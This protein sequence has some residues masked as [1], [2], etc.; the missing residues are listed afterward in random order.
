LKPLT[1][2]ELLQVWETGLNRPLLEKSLRLLDIA[3]SR[4][5]LDAVSTLSIGERDARLLQL[6]E[7]MFGPRLFNTAHCPK[8]T[9][10][11]EW[12]TDLNALYLQPLLPEQASKEF[13]LDIDGFLLHFRLLNSNDLLKAASGTASEPRE[14][15]APCILHVQHEQQPCQVDALPEPIWEALQQRMAEEDPQ[16]DIQMLVHCPV[17]AYGWQMPFDI[18]SYLWTEIDN[19]AKHML[20]EVFIL[21]RAFGWAER[22]ILNMSAQRRQLYLEM[23]KS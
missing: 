14:M 10:A 20:Q 8:C 1:A 2:T 13:S 18:M 5:G 7:W 23:L 3:C 4:P 6:R 11:V 9:A 15:L 12:E 19:W 17:C 22:D 21:A 16:A